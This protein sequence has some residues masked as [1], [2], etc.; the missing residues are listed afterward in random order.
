M[1]F[2]PNVS[3]FFKHTPNPEIFLPDVQPVPSL[4]DHSIQLV[5]ECLE[6]AGMV[7]FPALDK[8]QEPKKVNDY[9]YMHQKHVIIDSTLPNSPSV[10]FLL[11][12]TDIHLSNDSDNLLLVIETNDYLGSAT[13]REHNP[14]THSLSDN[15]KDILIDLVALLLTPPNSVKNRDIRKALQVPHSI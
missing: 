11:Q 1:R 9:Y 8:L 14:I 3:M 10:N 5:K 7:S 4:M 15:S 13:L 6:N 12:N 2:F